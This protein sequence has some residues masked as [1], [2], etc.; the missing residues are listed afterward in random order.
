METRSALTPTGIAQVIPQAIQ[1][2]FDPDTQ[3][4][5]PLPSDGNSSTFVRNFGKFERPGSTFSWK[6]FRPGR[7]K[8]IGYSKPRDMAEKANK[9]EL[10]LDCIRRL[11]NNNYI[12]EGLRVEF[13]RNFSDDDNDSVKLVT[14][15]GSRFIPETAILEQA[16]LIKFLKNFYNPVVHSYGSELFPTGGQ[17]AP[18]TGKVLV[19]DNVHKDPFDPER[20]FKTED[21]LMNYI[22]KLQREGHPKGRIEDYFRQKIKHFHTRPIN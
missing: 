8:L 2:A 6:I 13:Y 1:P 15:Y 3:P 12:R 9:Q 4:T 22:E 10:L 11:A 16:W 7:E 20:R 21:A 19:P 5:T 17:P 14:M 18:P